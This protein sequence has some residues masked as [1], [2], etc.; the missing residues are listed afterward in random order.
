MYSLSYPAAYYAAQ[1]GI[2]LKAKDIPSRNILFDLLGTL[3]MMKREIGP[4]DTVDIE[5][6]SSAYVENFALQVFA[7]AD[8]EDRRGDG[9]RLV[10]CL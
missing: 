1:I 5:A 7:T 6:V 8:N 2:S 3:E 9:N 10:R 4:N